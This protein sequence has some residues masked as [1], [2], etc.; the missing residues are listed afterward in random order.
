LASLKARP[1]PWP[2]VSMIV[3]ARP[4]AERP[5]STARLGLRAIFALRRAENADARY[6]LG[7]T[8]NAG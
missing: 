7:I 8:E 6:N 4:E 3:R 1:E 5:L 2:Q